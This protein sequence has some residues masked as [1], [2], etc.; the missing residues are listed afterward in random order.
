[1]AQIIKPD[2]NHMEL[3]KL[4]QPETGIPYKSF[5]KII[6]SEYEKLIADIKMPIFIERIKGLV[7]EYTIESHA[8][9]SSLDKVYEEESRDLRLWST[10]NLNVLNPSH[11]ITNG[12]NNLDSGSFLYCSITLLL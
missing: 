1:M 7:E 5:F 9:F 6:Y 4:A 3:I 2:K 10:S 12:K 11:C 8:R